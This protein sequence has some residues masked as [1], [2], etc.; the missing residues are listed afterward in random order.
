MNKLKTT[1][2]ALV[3]TSALLAG[4]QSTGL[5]QWGNYEQS[6]Y[7]Y[8]KD[9]AE[10]EAHAKAILK[11][12]ERS[13]GKVAPGLYAEYGTI[14]LQQGKK[15]EAIEY[16]TKERDLWPESQH[17]MNAMINNLSRQTAKAG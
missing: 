16:Y 6:L 5:Y 15:A 9:P 12:I 11:A 1:A 8:Y 3:A 17:L 10:L 13:N 2:I 7:N 4:C 14:L